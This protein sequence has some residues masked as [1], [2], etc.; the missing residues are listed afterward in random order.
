MKIKLEEKVL[1][2][3]D[4]IANQNR[5][6]F[7]EKN[8]YV[9]NIISSPGAGK[10]SI[11]EKF[12]YKL[13]PDITAYVLIGDV[14]TEND[15]RRIQ[16]AGYDARQIITG[17]ACHLNAQMIGK[18]VESI[19][20]ERLD[21][22]IIEN[23]GNLVCPAAYDLGEDD[24]IVVLSVTEGED[25]PIKYPAIFNK[26]TL[27]LL[28]KVDLLPH[29]KFDKKKA[30]DYALAVNA[31]LKVIETSCVTGE[32]FDELFQWV[33]SNINMKKARKHKV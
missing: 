5:D 25:K 26:A 7:K 24:K 27:M 6:L 29:L 22:L 17:G 14:Q 19:D 12:L 10:T 16:D 9:I 18:N 31:Q 15:A 4:K 1:S 33:R 20:L 11:L 8:L 23:V 28:H 2:E 30:I 21:M 3:N 13:S 32:G